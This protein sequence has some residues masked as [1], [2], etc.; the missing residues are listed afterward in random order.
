MDPVASS[1]TPK[2]MIMTETMLAAVFEGEDSPVQM[3][4]L[5]LPEIRP[6]EVLVRLSGCGICHADILVRDGYLPVQRPIVLG[7]EGSGYVERVG[8]AVTTVVEGDPVVLTSMT[9]GECRSCIDGEA[10][11]CWQK[12]PANFSGRR[13]DGSTALA[14]ATGEVGAH[15]FGQ[16]SFATYSVAH[17]RNVVKVRADAPLQILGPLGC[18]IQTGAGAVLNLLKPR[19]GQSV[20]IF[21]AGSVGLSAVLAAVV[22][23]CHQIVVVEPRETRRALALELGATHAIDPFATGD[24]AAEIQQITG[25]G[26]DKALDTSGRLEI[27]GAAWQSLANGGSC[28][29]VAPPGVPDAAFPVPVLDLVNRG[30]TLHGGTLGNRDPHAFIPYL[31][32]LFMDGRFPFDKMVELYPFR[33]L[34]RAME[35]HEAG[36]AIKPVLTMA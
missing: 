16:S 10:Y 33:D 12:M 17:R 32:D 27:I 25:G 20:T 2:D 28:V 35:D 8:S 26:T 34:A 15:F 18:G 23:Q 24:I 1:L 22:A 4:G 3:K 13:L 5:A 6:D 9:C 14:D 19:P 29:L 30:V 36:R 31:I 21:G 7:H 11:N